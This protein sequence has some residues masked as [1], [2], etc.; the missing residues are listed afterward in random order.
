MGAA[1]HD[2]I[3]ERPLAP[4]RE[5]G[6]RLITICASLAVALALYLAGEV[7]LRDA[8]TSGPPAAPSTPAR[9]LERMAPPAAPV[10]TP[11]SADPGPLA[12]HPGSNAVMKCTAQG[13]TSYSDDPCPPGATATPV[14]IQPGLNIAAPVLAP[15]PA[16]SAPPVVVAATQ[17]PQVQLA[18]AA[19]PDRSTVRNLCQVL[20]DEIKHIDAMAKQPQSAETQDNLAARRK[21]ARDEQFRIK[22]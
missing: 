22:C 13:R 20:D 9:K 3:R 14:R 11:G 4:P 8:S 16:P 17:P 12:Q 10:H 2:E 15:Q 19:P 1:D 5:P 6:P 21:R 7:W 18:V